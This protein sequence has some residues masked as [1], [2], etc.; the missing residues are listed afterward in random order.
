MSISAVIPCYNAAPWLRAAIESAFRQSRPA[1]EVIVVDDGSTD[2]SRTIASEYPVRIL[3]MPTNRGHATARNLALR[4]ATHDIVAWLD[5][6]DYWDPHHCA[7]VVP[8][9]EAH[10][11]AAVAFSAVRQL[12][13]VTG[14]WSMP[15]AC[16][17]PAF[18]FWEC[19]ATT[20][21]PAMS[22][23]TRRQPALEIGAF[24]EELRVA[25]DFDFWLRLS[26]KHPFV[27][28]QQA[29]SNYRR[30]AHQISSDPLAQ[31]CSTYHARALVAAETEQAGDAA[32]ARRMRD[33]ARDLLDDELANAWWAADMTTLRALLALADNCGFESAEIRKVRRLSRLPAGLVRGWRAL[34]RAMRRGAL[35]GIAATSTR[36]RSAPPRPPRRR[37]R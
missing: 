19:F 30:H 22:A 27:W 37:P 16:Q 6:D 8:L 14:V 28:T 25:P 7:V 36:S 15:T 1:A 31:L 12:G 18:L 26:L 29:T 13:D 10:P 24:R 35:S 2:A 3:E 32:L 11:T 20:I 5:A 9:L 23:I 33:R 4:E 34:Q 21:V 17:E